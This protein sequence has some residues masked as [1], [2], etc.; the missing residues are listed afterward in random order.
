V[1][2]LAGTQINGL[3]YYDTKIDNKFGLPNFPKKL[4]HTLHKKYDNGRM[5]ENETAELA[6]D[7]ES[8]GKKKLFDMAFDLYDS[9]INSKMLLIDE[10]DSKIHPLITKEIIKELME[11]KTGKAQMIFTTHDTIFLAKEI[12]RRDQIWLTEKDKYGMSCL[13]SLSDFKVRN[14]ASY[15]K[16]YIL[17]KY[18]GVPFIGNIESIFEQ[19]FEDK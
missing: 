3:K 19:S 15:G 8:D 11:V 1:L 18:G 5:L 4:I 16:D 9:F 13:Y 10:I 17:G 6:M 7:K 14:D 2:R 12:F